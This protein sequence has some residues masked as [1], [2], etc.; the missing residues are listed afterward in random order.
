MKDKDILTMLKHLDGAVDRLILTQFDFPR[1]ATVKE[2]MEQ[3][4]EVDTEWKME[5]RQEKNWYQAYQELVQSA[6][7][8]EIIMITGSL[9]F[10]SEVR[11]KLKK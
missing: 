9:Y 4:K 8:N 7:E 6:T 3:L 2:L 11:T 5:I 1:A 10:I